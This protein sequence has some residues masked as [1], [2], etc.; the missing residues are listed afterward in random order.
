MFNLHKNLRNLVLISA[1]VFISL[2]IFIAVLPAYD[3]HY[4]QALPSMEPFTEAEQ[5]GLQVYVKENC[6]ACHTQQVRNIEMDNVWGDRPAIPSDYYYSKAR[7]DFWRQSPSILGSERT[8]PDLTNVGKRQSGKDWHL[9]HLYNPRIVVKE[10][11][12]PGYPWMFE[13]KSESEIS[14]NDV[15]VPVPQEFLKNTN[16]KIVATEQALNLTAYLISL[17]QPDINGMPVMDFIPAKE[18]KKASASSSAGS[19]TGLDG[20]ALYAS[21]CAACHQADGKGLSGAFPALA[22]SP[23]VTGE[24]TQLYLDIILRGYDSRPEYAVMMGFADILTNEEI[25]AIATHERQSWGNDGPEV[26]PEEV[27]EVRDY[28]EGLNQ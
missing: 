22:G 8:G 10:S 9:L 7:L 1:V 28:I 13:E 21:N 24:D 12:M 25:A 16:K 18:D 27:Q 2:S 17:K 3:L 23:I 26:T 19:S 14:D 20:A 11:I 4:V 5:K 6:V 15:V